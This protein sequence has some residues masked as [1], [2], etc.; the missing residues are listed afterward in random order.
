MRKSLLK[1]PCPD[2]TNYRE[3]KSTLKCFLAGRLLT[4]NKGI[5]S[6]TLNYKIFLII[7]V[8]VRLRDL[9]HMDMQPTMSD[10]NINTLTSPHS[11]FALPQQQSIN[12]SMMG[13]KLIHN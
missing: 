8:T 7:H 3:P 1:N 13:H 6:K 5:L 10:P 4:M 12:H 2:R 11:L 9:R